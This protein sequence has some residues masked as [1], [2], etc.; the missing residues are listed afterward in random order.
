[1]ISES[2]FGASKSERIMQDIFQEVI[3]MDDVRGVMFLAPDGGIRFYKF[4]QESITAPEKI[5]WLPLMLAELQ[6]MEEAELVYERARLYI[7]SS[8]TGVLFV[9]AEDMANL[10][11]IRLNCDVA[12]NSW[13][14]SGSQQ[15]KG[16]KRG[17]FRR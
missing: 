3:N 12:L 15:S 9:W 1:M 7:R 2:R 4:A 11:R 10:S 17:F 13:E 5:D 16:K 8:S 6:G 14:Q